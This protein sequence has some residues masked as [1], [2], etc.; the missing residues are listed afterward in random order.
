MLEPSEEIRLA[1]VEYCTYE[2]ATYCK[3]EDLEGG[4]RKGWGRRVEDGVLDTFKLK[5]DLNNFRY[6]ATQAPHVINV[7]YPKSHRP[8]SQWPIRP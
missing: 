5:S 2:L 1:T 7:R 8:H 3:G 4:V 6:V